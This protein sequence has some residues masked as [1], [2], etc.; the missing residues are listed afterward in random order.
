[1]TRKYWAGHVEG[2]GDTN[3]EFWWSN[4]VESGH[5][6]DREKDGKILRWKIVS[7]DGSG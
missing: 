2:M 6:E 1:V 5:L 3:R 4:S 7:Y